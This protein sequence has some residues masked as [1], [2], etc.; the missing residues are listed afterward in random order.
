MNEIHTYLNVPSRGRAISADE[1]A[2]GLAGAGGV[3]RGSGQDCGCGQNCQPPE[4]PPAPCPPPL[5]QIDEPGCKESFEAAFRLLCDCELRTLLDLDQMAFV[6]ESFIAGANLVP[7]T[8]ASEVSDNLSITLSGS[9]LRPSCGTRDVLDISGAP[10]CPVPDVT[11]PLPFTATRVSLCELTAAAVQVA[12][13][14]GD[15]TLTAEEVTTRSY[16]R[17]KRLLSARLNP[18]RSPGETCAC[19]LSGQCDCSGGM[20]DA[21][22]GCGSGRDIN[23]TA[24]PLAL[25]GVE[26]LGTVG[27]VMV[28]AGDDSQRI[29]FVCL[30]STAFL[31]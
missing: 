25:L 11:T 7:V 9:Y 26:L 21:I 20:L 29:Y 2:A 4:P 5:P 12:A 28:L 22:T 19:R 18:C 23:L 31:G 1:F 24:G 15:G 8:D 3:F 13:M 14:T 17:A 16:N 27:N 30:N 10:Y 6:T